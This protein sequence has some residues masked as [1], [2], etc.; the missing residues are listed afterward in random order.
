MDE[1]NIVSKFMTKVISGIMSKAL[2][3]QLGC[4][5]ELQLNE[6]KIKFDGV[7]ALVHLDIDA[8]LRTGDILKLSNK[9]M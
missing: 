3:N 9:F 7:K 4:K 5:V 2:G 6:M 8:E 1:M